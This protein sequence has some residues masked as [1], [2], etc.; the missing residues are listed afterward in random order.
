MVRQQRKALE[1]PGAS[2]NVSV[3]QEWTDQG[4]KGLLLG[5]V[6]A[7]NLDKEALRTRSGRTLEA[8]PLAILSGLFCFVLFAFVKT[9]SLLLAFAL[10]KAKEQLSAHSPCV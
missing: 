10:P 8:P 9:V 6:K 2:G 7:S 5:A 1:E 3:L 4:Y